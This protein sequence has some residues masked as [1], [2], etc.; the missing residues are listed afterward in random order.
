MS[1]ALQ[2]VCVVGVGAIGGV[3]AAW[4]GSRLPAGRIHLSAL[5]R[6]DTLRALQ[7]NELR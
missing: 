1:V 6:G 3:F 2:K 7:S 5:A 4:L